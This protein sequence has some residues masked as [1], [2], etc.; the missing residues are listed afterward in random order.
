MIPVSRIISTWW[1]VRLWTIYEYS[2]VVVDATTR[3]YSNSGYS[4]GVEQQSE[5]QQQREIKKLSSDPRI[6]GGTPAAQGDY[7]F[8]VNTIRPILCGGTLIAPDIVLTAAHCGGGFLAGVNIGGTLL[9]GS[10]A[11]TVNVD[12]E[13]PHPDYVEADRI[14]DIMLVKLSTPSTAPV[15][16][17]NFDPTIPVEGDTATLI[18]FGDTTDGGTTSNELLMVDVDIYADQF[19]DDLYNSFI[20]ETMLCAGTVAGGRD[21]C[22]GDSGGPILTPDNVQLGVVSNGNGCGRPNIPAIYTEVSAFESFIRQG[23]C[24]MYIKL[25]QDMY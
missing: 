10:N 20:P 14:N 1:I 23:I 8:Y 9:D 16:Q 2:S 12:S 4:N 11:E 19:C 5:H 25:A 7:P 13:F 6:V 22:Q 3:I 24:G 15:V 21:S 18:G 17:L